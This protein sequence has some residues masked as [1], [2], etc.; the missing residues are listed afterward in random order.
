MMAQGMGKELKAQEK[1]MCE[2]KEKEMDQEL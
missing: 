1:M 2:E